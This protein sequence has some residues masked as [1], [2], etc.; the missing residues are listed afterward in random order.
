VGLLIAFLLCGIITA[1]IASNKGRSGFGWFFIGMMTG[2][3]GII[4]ALVV[5]NKSAK[6]AGAALFTQ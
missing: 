2:L 3:V 5:S 1:V 4:I 6:A